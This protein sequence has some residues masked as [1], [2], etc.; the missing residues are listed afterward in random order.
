MA[1]Y[2]ALVNFTDQGIQNIRDLPDRWDEAR[3]GIE[4]AG[5]SIEYYLTM[6]QY[7]AVVITDFPSDEVGAAA[8]L[9]IGSRG[10]VRTETLKAFTE[11]ETRQIISSMPGG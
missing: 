6:G 4:A 7:D 1:T 11:E 5:G 9:S 8:A 2:I 10:N 3:K